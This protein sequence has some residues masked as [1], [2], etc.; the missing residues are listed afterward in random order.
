MQIPVVDYIF[1]EFFFSFSV[2]NIHKSLEKFL[3]LIPFLISTEEIKLVEVDWGRE[4]VNDS[5]PSKFRVLTGMK[6]LLFY[7]MISSHRNQRFLSSC[8]VGS[9]LLYPTDVDHTD[10]ILNENFQLD[11]SRDLFEAV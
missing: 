10:D 8:L 6:F 1:R 9:S 5:V 4:L 7:L 11:K 2:M 3:S